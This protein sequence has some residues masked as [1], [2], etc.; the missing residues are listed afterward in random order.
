[1]KV[2]GLKIENVKRLKAVELNP[3][4]A[5]VVVGGNNGQGKSSILDSILF[6]LGGSGTHCEKPIREGAERAEITLNL[7]DLVVT[8]RF[9]AG[10]STLVVKNKDGDTKA[11]PQAI[12]DKLVGSLTFDPM[13]FL[14]LDAKTQ[15]RC[16]AEMAGVNTT[17]FDTE[18]QGLYDQRRDWTRRR[19]ELAAKIAGRTVFEGLPAA[20]IVLDDLVKEYKAAQEVN[21]AKVLADKKVED[22]TRR[23]S[24]AHPQVMQAEQRVQRLEAELAIAKASLKGNRDALGDLNSVLQVAIEQAKHH[25]TADTD[26][27]SKR[28]SE[29]DGVNAKIRS[30]VEIVAMEGELMSLDRRISD[31]NE[32]MDKNSAAKIAAIKS[33]KY[34]LPGLAVTD[35][36]VLF[37][38]IPFKQVNTAAQVQISTAM[39][40]AQN[41]TLRVMLIRHGSDLDPASLNALLALAAQHD[42][43]VWIE[44]VGD[45]MECS[46]VIEDGEIR[47]NN[48]D[49]ITVHGAQ[50]HERLVKLFG[51]KTDSTF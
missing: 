15:R 44:R 22:Y 12:L 47:R 6:A 32:A 36:S 50:E 33:A 28:I 13:E 5:S 17:N 45:G 39:A 31:I 8:R 25:P 49:W 29:A 9:T 34:P 37:E 35:D 38:G 11:S 30:N 26:S 51:K 4:G 27:I 20:A 42:I 3:N 24:D 19:N 23:V 2:I 40:I 7:G 46:V 1:M 43:Q 10:G 14:R 16:L 41:P 18:F 21:A 48:P